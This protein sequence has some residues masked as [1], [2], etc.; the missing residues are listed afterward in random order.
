MKLIICIF[1]INIIIIFKYRCLKGRSS[2]LEAQVSEVAGRVTATLHLKEEETTCLRAQYAALVEK[3]K[4]MLAE[5]R[6]LDFPPCPTCGDVS[7]W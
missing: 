4:A 1:N 5:K 2:E 6:R 3:N 7:E